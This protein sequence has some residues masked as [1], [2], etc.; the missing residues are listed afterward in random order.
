[1]IMYADDTVLLT[2]N[3]NTEQLEIDTYIAFNM[4]QE[5]TVKND[6]VLNEGK[7]KQMSLGSKKALISD[8]PGLQAVDKIKHLGIT[9][10]E[11]MHW[12]NHIDSLCLKLNSA[13]FAL[14]RT[15]ATSTQEATR[16]AYHALFESHLR[17]GITVWGGSSEGNLH[18]ALVVQKKQLE[19]WRN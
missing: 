2:A 13:L 9:I 18:R 19:S 4:A 3:R 6:L 8:L 7:T 12:K 17:Y 16:I 10:D 11:N 5:Y 14:K 15:K 1:M